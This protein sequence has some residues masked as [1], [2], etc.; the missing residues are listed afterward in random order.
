MA[1]IITFSG[2]RWWDDGSSWL[3]VYDFY[4]NLKKEFEIPTFANTLLANSLILGDY[5][6][7]GITDI[8][9]FVDPLIDLGS[10]FDQ[11]NTTLFRFN[12]GDSKYQEKNMFWPITMHDF[13]NNAC[14]NCS[15]QFKTLNETSNSRIE[16]PNNQEINGKLSIYIEKNLDGKWINF[17]NITIGKSIDLTAFGIF[18]LADFF[19]SQ[20][21]SINEIGYYR[22]RAVFS[23][24]SNILEQ[25]SEF[26]VV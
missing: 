22:V 9:L 6:Q 21:I 3:R 12:L 13:S 15:Q 4:G 2:R 1:E 26:D 5:D 11:D 25:N 17:M 7:D 24:N 19:N 16:N 18:D 14:Y 10:T 8:S 23:Y 20:N